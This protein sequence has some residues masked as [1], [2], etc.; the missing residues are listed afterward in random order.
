MGVFLI[1][2]LRYPYIVNK[3]VFQD[4][5]NISKPHLVKDVRNKIQACLLNTLKNILNIF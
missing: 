2:Y 4:V 5:L 1:K 3:I